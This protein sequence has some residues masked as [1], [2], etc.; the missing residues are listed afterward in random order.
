M[1]FFLNSILAIAILICYFGATK[2]FFRVNDRGAKRGRSLYSVVGGAAILI[3]IYCFFRAYTGMVDQGRFGVFAL[4]LY[5]ASI[6]IFFSALYANRT[7]RLNFA[8]ADTSSASIT[9][10]GV[11]R[12]VRHPLYT[13]YCCTWIAGFLATND[14]IALLS[15]AI[16]LPYYIAAARLEE[17]Q[18]IESAL[19]S[20]YIQYKSET[21]M[22]F[23]RVVALKKLAG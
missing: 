21:G 10:S 4:S 22:F 2:Y 9:S 23:P 18:F 6:I 19:G 16:C 17:R 7:Q 5:V 3:Q 12:F 13:S 15:F 14:P 11:Y 1:W 8:F 20:S